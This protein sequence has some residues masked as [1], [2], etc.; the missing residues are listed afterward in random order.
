MK[1]FCLQKA[2][3]KKG[4]AASGQISLD[5]ILAL[6]VLGAFL[7]VLLA[8]SDQ[9]AASQAQAALY[10]QARGLAR[11]TA[12]RL[13]TVEA[14]GPGFS[15]EWTLPELREPGNGKLPGCEVSV[16]NGRVQ[17]KAGEANA[18]QPV[19]ARA[20]LQANCGEKVLVGEHG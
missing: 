17:V 11:E 15:L 10:Q 3:G 5:L 9:V 7:Q 12:Q 6:I 18:E 13:E 19:Q 4:P 1:P 14:L 2:L 8:F 20:A 16:G